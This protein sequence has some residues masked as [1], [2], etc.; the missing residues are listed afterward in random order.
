M[1]AQQTEKDVDV[2]I[3]PYMGIEKQRTVFDADMANE[4]VIPVCV[5]VT[6]RSSRTILVRQSDVQLVVEEGSILPPISPRD[7]SIQ[8]EKSPASGA[9]IGTTVVG[10]L[11]GGPIVGTIAGS[12]VG[13]SAEKKNLEAST[14]RLNDFNKKGLRDAKLAPQ[15]STQGFVYFNILDKKIDFTKAVCTIRIIDFEGATSSIFQ[16]QLANDTK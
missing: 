5:L 4:G 11:V 2:A 13:Q 15:D 12:M 1:P 14:N 8:F 7:A 3:D 6:N 10:T 16:F 9:A